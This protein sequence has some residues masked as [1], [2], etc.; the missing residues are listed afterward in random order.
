MKLSLAVIVKNEYLEVQR[1]IREYEKYF[2]ELVFAVDNEKVLQ[3]LVSLYTKSCIKFYKYEWINDFADKRNFLTSKLTGDYYLRIDTDDKIVN[4]ERIR[5]LAEYADKNNYSVVMCL[6]YY[7]KDDDGNPNA[8]Q[9]RETIIKRDENLYWNKKIHECIIPKRLTGYKVHV[10]ETLKL[11]HLI[12]V[13]HARKSHERNLGYLI[14][15]Y[16]ETKSNP[17]PRTLAYLGRTFFTLRSSMEVV[18]I[19]YQFSR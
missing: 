12:D 17:D 15:E 3:E 7:A 14:K 8:V 9:Y 4:P 6:Y 2:D 18:S 19:K 10:D 1:I 11:D 16:N 13:D 5:P